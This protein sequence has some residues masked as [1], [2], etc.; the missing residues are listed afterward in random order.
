[1]TKQIPKTQEPTKSTGNF[2]IYKP[3][4]SGINANSKELHQVHESSPIKQGTFQNKLPNRNFSNEV[5]ES[6]IYSSSLDQ[7]QQVINEDTDLVFN[8]LVAADYIDEIKCTE[9]SSQQNA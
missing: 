2:R 4:P 3:K 8:A 6:E 5:N 9:V 1:M 7:V